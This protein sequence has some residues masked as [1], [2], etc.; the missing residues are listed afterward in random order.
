MIR[1]RKNGRKLEDII[2]IS[3]NGKSASTA[4][5]SALLNHILILFSSM[6]EIFYSPFL[7][8]NLVHL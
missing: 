3:A 2:C 1:Q 7:R 8:R 6:I 5:V 4:Y